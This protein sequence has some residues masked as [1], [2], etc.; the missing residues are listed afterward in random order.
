MYLVRKETKYA[1]FDAWI[2]GIGAF[3]MTVGKENAMLEGIR[4]AHNSMDNIWKGQDSFPAIM[5]TKET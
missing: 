5:E 4:G 1:A 2:P 3:Q